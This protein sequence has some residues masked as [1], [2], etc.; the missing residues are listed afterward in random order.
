MKESG[1]TRKEIINHVVQWLCRA[2]HRCFLI[3][4][5]PG[6]DDLRPDVSQLVYDQFLA[7]QP[8]NA[9]CARISV[10]FFKDETVLV[11]S[12]I[13]AWCNHDREMKDVWN[14]ELAYLE[15]DLAGTHLLAF[16]ECA[17]K[18]ERKLFAVFSHFDRVFRFMSGSLLARMRDLEQ[19]SKLLSCVNVST[20]PY[21]EL[22]RIR[23]RTE[24]GFTS[25]YG[26]V[27]V[28]MALGRLHLKEAEEIWREETTLTLDD[29]LERQYFEIAYEESGGFPNAFLIA[30]GEL[31]PESLNSDV[32]DFRSVLKKA[33]PGCFDRILRHLD[34]SGE[35]RIIDAIARVSL[36]AQTRSDLD[37]LHE[38]RWSR[39][40]VDQEA[41]PLAL[42]CDALGRKAVEMTNNLPANQRLSPREL[43]CQ[44]RFGACLNLL[45]SRKSQ[46]DE[47]LPLAAEMMYE[48][49]GGSPNDLY[50][51]PDINWR[52]VA[53]LGA[54]AAN[55]C[56]NQEVRIDFENWIRVAEVHI[57]WPS[58]NRG[59]LEKHLDSLRNAGKLAVEKAI[60]RLGIRLL[61]IQRDRNAVTAAYTAVPLVEELLRHYVV[62]VLNLPQLGS[63]F[64]GI[65]DESIMVW[66]P[67]IESFI[68]PGPDVRLNATSL[69]V[70][71]ALVSA[72]RNQALFETPQD[73]H[74]MLT[75]LENARNPLGHHV[76]TPTDRLVG[77]LVSHAK[78]IL[79]KMRSH[80]DSPIS[81]DVVSE[82]VSPPRRFL[83]L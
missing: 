77:T 28:Q 13:Q 65:D 69:A 78:F 83:G 72:L 80:A 20:L 74:R 9:M 31:H 44:G 36:G 5:P 81:L 21:E 54:I 26:Q 70:A 52:K 51:G 79:N 14:E 64:N 17:R 71:A 1:F 49:Y 10:D 76:L 67:R 39:L 73:L 63:V 32:R 61:A 57:E 48:V 35:T 15:D 68:R 30:A 46:A 34:E 27:H 55:N 60:I 18:L 56:P 29:R 8:K 19:N 75:D 62:L 24:P 45:K 11:E 82:M 22:Y 4:A 33:L 3:L 2:E 12:L 40:F 23:A 53:R 41:R 42:S 43:Y 66:W 25:D 50:F 38:H 7:H 47:I 16:A 6:C 58:E 59:T 37:A